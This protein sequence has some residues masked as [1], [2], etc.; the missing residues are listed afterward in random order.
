LLFVWIAPDKRDAFVGCVA[1]GKLD[2]PAPRVIKRVAVV[3]PFLMDA[4]A[5]IGD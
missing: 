2:S 5:A 3:F 1:L 4:L